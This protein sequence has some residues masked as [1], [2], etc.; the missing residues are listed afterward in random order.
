[1][2]HLFYVYIINILFIVIDIF[3]RKEEFS[4]FKNVFSVNSSYLKIR[5]SDLSISGNR[6]TEIIKALSKFQ[7][8]FYLF[9]KKG[10]LFNE[11]QKIKINFQKL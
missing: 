2:I 11:E 6:T 3:L 9:Q 8:Y 7:Y 5:I 4:D 10:Y 1:M